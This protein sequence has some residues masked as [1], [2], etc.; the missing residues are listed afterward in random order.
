MSL[1][2]SDQT[3]A[4][5]IERDTKRILAAIEAS[6]KRIIAAMARTK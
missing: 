4:R 6:E 3:I 1:S 5:Q 2:T